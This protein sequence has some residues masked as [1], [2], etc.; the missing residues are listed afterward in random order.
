MLS[1]SALAPHMASA[2]KAASGTADPS[3]VRAGGGAG[4]PLRL[5]S[6]GGSAATSSCAVPQGTGFDTNSAPYAGACGAMTGT[7]GAA[8]MGAG[9]WGVW[10]GTACICGGAAAGT[11]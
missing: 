5:P 4:P 1:R 10:P 3:T 6:A 8:G 7:D 9:T 11:G 2:A